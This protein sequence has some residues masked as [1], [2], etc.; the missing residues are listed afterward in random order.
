M[1]G[2]KNLLAA[3]FRLENSRSEQ[4]I[5][6]VVRHLLNWLNAEEQSGLRDSFTVWFNRVLLPGKT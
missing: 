5:Q 3:L 1:S 2:L 4:D 6:S